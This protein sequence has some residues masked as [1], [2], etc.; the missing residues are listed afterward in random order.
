M[1]EVVAGPPC[2]HFRGDGEAAAGGGGCGNG[3]V[4]EI[5]E[6]EEEEKE[7]SH[8]LVWTERGMMDGDASGERFAHSTAC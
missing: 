2:G 1:G 5:V 7:W 6:G 3:E 4:D 8:D